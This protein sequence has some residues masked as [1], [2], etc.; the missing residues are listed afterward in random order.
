VNSGRW[1]LGD[2]PFALSRAPNA[3]RRLDISPSGTGPESR[4]WRSQPRGRGGRWRRPGASVSEVRSPDPL[5]PKPHRR[6]RANRLATTLLDRLAALCAGP[7]TAR[8]LRWRARPVPR[9]R[10]WQA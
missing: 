2:P 9:L 1:R 7:M 10:S 6:S 3:P 4:P 5:Q 8:K